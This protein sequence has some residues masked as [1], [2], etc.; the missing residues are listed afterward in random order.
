MLQGNIVPL[1]S[2]GGPLCRV[3]LGRRGAG[4]SPSV[5]GSI[6]AASRAGWLPE[7]FQ[8]FVEF[9]DGKA[10]DVVEGAADGAD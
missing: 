5:A 2:R 3:K 10:H 7:S 9:V 8:R 6:A 4:V 1:A